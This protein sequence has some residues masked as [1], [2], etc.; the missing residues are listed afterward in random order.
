M[1]YQILHYVSMLTISQFSGWKCGVWIHDSFNAINTTSAEYFTNAE[2]IYYKKL[3]KDRIVYDTN[4]YFHQWFNNLWII[5]LLQRYANKCL[6]DLWSLISP[7]RYGI[8][9]ESFFQESKLNLQKVYSSVTWKQITRC[10]YNEFL[11][12]S[13][14][15]QY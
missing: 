9:F 10:V 1:Q 15:M 2:T 13:D 8:H 14:C 11:L 7:Q 5:Q 3:W 12:P 6:V 4:S